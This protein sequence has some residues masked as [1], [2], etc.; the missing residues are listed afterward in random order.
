MGPTKDYVHKERGADLI[1]EEGQET[2]W[3]NTEKMEEWR[4]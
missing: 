1:G 3:N 2:W 4:S